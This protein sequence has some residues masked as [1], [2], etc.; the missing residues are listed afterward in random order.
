MEVKA[1]CTVETTA[2][3]HALNMPGERVRL[4]YAPES[5]LGVPVVMADDVLLFARAGGDADYGKQSFSVSVERA[6]LR[7][8]LPAD[9]ETVTLAVDAAGTLAVDGQAVGGAVSS[10]AREHANQP[11]TNAALPDPRPLLR[12]WIRQAKKHD[13]ATA[14]L[15]LPNVPVGFAIILSDKRGIAAAQLGAD[16][17]EIGV[18]EPD[19]DRWR[20]LTDHDGKEIKQAFRLLTPFEIETLR[21]EAL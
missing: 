9:A 7:D 4:D 19:G 1:F 12:K 20:V 18:I 3:R 15:P 14:F 17:L 21:S 5:N 11:R 13:P 6:L 16:A 8:R 10:R 2:L